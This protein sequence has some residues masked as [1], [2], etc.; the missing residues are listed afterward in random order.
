MIFS[1]ARL[2]WKRYTRTPMIW[3]AGAISLFLLTYMFLSF[4]EN[5]T[6]TVQLENA[7]Q[8]QQTGVTDAVATPTLL[9]AGML[10]LGLMPLIALRGFAEESQLKTR[11]LFCSST[12]RPWQWLIGKYLG[13]MAPLTVYVL[14]VSLMPLSLLLGTTLD[15]G[16]V[17]SGSLGL[18]LLL[19]SFS[20]AALYCSTLS[21]SVAPAAMLTFG[22]LILFTV[23]YIVGG[24]SN[25]STDALYQLAHFGH[26]P[27]F[28]QGRFTLADTGYYAIFATIFLWLAYRRLAAQQRRRITP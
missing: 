19:N 24:S 26:F 23:L 13:V 17:A 27:P 15:L 7:T 11:S 3:I 25:R 6:Q 18:W 1:I 20:A 10:G 21:K 22:L 8:Q 4:M 16:K 9:W 12:I 28:L 5:F 2:E 14:L